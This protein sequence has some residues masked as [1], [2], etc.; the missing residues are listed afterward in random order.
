M[1]CKDIPEL[2]ALQAIE[3]ARGAGVPAYGLL[4]DR[5]GA[6]EKVAFRKLEQIEARGELECG[7]HVG[8]GWLTGKGARRLIELGGVVKSELTRERLSQSGPW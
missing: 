3:D 6:P 4:M 2:V 7:L 1:Q 8:V 5:S